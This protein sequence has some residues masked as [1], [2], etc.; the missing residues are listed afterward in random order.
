MGSGSAA[1]ASSG[2]RRASTGR[3]RRR[4]VLPA[5]AAEERVEKELRRLGVR[6]G[7]TVRIGSKVLEWTEGG[8]A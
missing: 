3:A 6:G 2:S 7:D 5:A 1:T 8:T 4:G